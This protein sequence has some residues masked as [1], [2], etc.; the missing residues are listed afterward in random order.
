MNY[1]YFEV[2][3]SIVVTSSYSMYWC[4]CILVLYIK[5]FELDSE[6]GEN[7]YVRTLLELRSFML[8]YVRTVYNCWNCDHSCWYMYVQCTIAGIA[9]IRVL[10]MGLVWL[11]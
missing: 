3:R 2:L 4:L 9:I 7:S 5:A 6:K 11:A 10:D 8:V 1:R